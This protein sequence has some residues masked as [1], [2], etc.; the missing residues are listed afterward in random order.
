M[1]GEK[2]AFTSR[3][4]QFH[5]YCMNQI[6]QHPASHCW[7]AFEAKHGRSLDG[8]PDVAGSGKKNIIC[9]ENKSHE[10]FFFEGKTREK[11]TCDTSHVLDNHVLCF[12]M[13]FLYVFFARVRVCEC[14]GMCVCVY[15]KS[16][17]VR[18]AWAAAVLCASHFYHQQLVLPPITSSYQ[19]SH[20][21]RE[22]EGGRMF[23]KPSRHI[24]HIKAP[25][26][27]SVK[28]NMAAIISEVADKNK[29]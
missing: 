15:W 17:V 10:N 25:P 14:M 1:R 6:T 8:R 20:A 16:S 27:N 26:L 2:H 4:L 24:C 29:I 18:T 23:A 19:S 21:C 3:Q 11:L 22:R 12:Y 7:F 5:M 28:T 9:E 13:W